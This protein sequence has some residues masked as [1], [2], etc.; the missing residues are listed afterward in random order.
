[1]VRLSS[2][3]KERLNLL[4]QK[5]QDKFSKSGSWP[6]S[7]DW[8]QYTIGK[9]GYFQNISEKELIAFCQ[10]HHTKIHVLVPFGFFVLEEAP[11][12]A[13]EKELSKEAID[14]FIT[15]LD[16]NPSE[17]VSNN[18]ILGFKQL[19]EIICK[20]MSPSVNDPGTALNAIDYLTEL[21]ALRMK[22]EDAYFIVDEQ[23]VVAK[24][25]AVTFEE[26]LQYVFSSLRSYVTHDP[27]IVQ[28]LLKSLVYLEGVKKVDSSFEQAV[29]AQR[30]IFLKECLPNA[31]YDRKN[32]NDLVHQL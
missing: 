32:A 15:F 4:I 14:E 20:A 13:S 23:L 5:E 3:A 18:Y 25:N 19:T 31:P 6:N 8:K 30:T 2:E 12:F 1:M 17:L 22:K 27:I 24:I 28:K 29:V 26:L 9:S 11:F 21:F 16:F 7:K 10:K